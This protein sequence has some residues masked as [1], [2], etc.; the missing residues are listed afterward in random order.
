LKKN[1]ANLIYPIGT[2]LL[3]AVVGIFLYRSSLSVPFLLDDLLFISSQDS[4][5]DGIRSFLQNQGIFK[6]RPL[7]GLSYA[8]NYEISK[9]SPL[10][11]HIINIILHA[12]NCIFLFFI[13]RKLIELPRNT[14]DHM[15]SVLLSLY[16]VLLFLIH[17][18]ATESVAYVSGRSSLLYTTF[19]L[20]AMLL[21]FKSAE[22]RGWKMVFVAVLSLLSYGAA[23]ASKE[24]SLIFP[25]ILFAVASFFALIPLKRQ[26]F[27][28]LLPSIFMSFLYV[29]ATL[30][31]VLFLKSPDKTSRDF[32]VHMMTEIYIFAESFLKAIFPTNLNFDPDYSDI[33]SPFDI[34][35]ITGVIIFSLLLSAAFYLRK[36]NRI[37]SFSIIWFVVSFSP[38]FFIRLRDYMF[39]RW[40]YF[41]LIAISFLCAGVLCEIFRKW[42]NKPLLKFI[43]IPPF[44]IIICSYTMLTVDRLSVWQSAVSIWTDTAKKSPHKFRTHANFGSALLKEGRF[45]EA[46]KEIE[47]AM[48]INSEYAEI[49]FDMAEVYRNTGRDELAIE[50]YNKALQYMPY[51]INDKNFVHYNTMINMGLIYF[52]H[53][54]KQEAINL[55]FKAVQLKPDL[56]QAYNNIGV[57][58][59][60]IGNFDKAEKSFLTAI[61]KRNNYEMA[62]V[63][64]ADL[65]MKQ[66][67]TEKAR[68]LLAKLQK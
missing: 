15:K 39:E 51:Y 6:S 35:F 55:F 61:A 49:H 45:A 25:L 10:G 50:E 3:I 9:N 33:I 44:L 34:R 13:I 8:I 67:E 29:I 2:I 30:P 59:M 21:F 17:P 18:L 63:N 36:R 54:E 1:R 42:E 57:I 14:F 5:I 24:I 64:L 58:F 43:T 26:I 19:L 11:Y 65:Y 41:P 27:I 7:L 56:P 22:D 46:K 62:Y 68:E 20:I 31:S 40:L 32:S 66:G 38:Y 16:G 12:V 37:I 60:S 47:E 4:S 23:L 52:K 48:S 28:F 53:N